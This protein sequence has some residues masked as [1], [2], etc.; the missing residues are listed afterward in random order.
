[1]KGLIVINNSPEKIFSEYR[2]CRSYKSALGS[3]GLYEQTAINE[4]FFAGDQWY[5]AACPSDRPL[6]RHNII[7]RIGDFKMSQLVSSKVSVR[8]SAEGVP[9]TVSDARNIANE[10]KALASRGSAIYTPLDSRNEA[11]L[12]VSALNSYRD[13]V[14]RRVGLSSLL[15]TALRN[16]YISGS[17]FIYTYFDPTVRTGLYA[18]KIGGKAILGDIACEVIRAENVYFG[19]PSVTKLQS[20]PY[21]ILAERKPFSD[22]A[23]EAAV[24]G[25]ADLAEIGES[26]ACEKCTLLTKLYKKRLEDGSIHIFAVKVCE[27]F[28]VREEWDTGVRLY[29]LSMFT[30][31]PRD[32]NIY[33]D[34]EVTYLIPNQIA[35]NRMITASVWSAMSTGMPLMLVNGELV[36]E[37]ITND[38][39]QI[40]RVWGSAEEI[41]SAV[42]YINPPDFST[43]YN[44]SVETLISNTLSQSGATDAALGDTEAHNTSAIIELREA[45]SQPLALLKNRYY[46]FIEDISIIWAEFFVTMYGKRSLKINDENGVWY[47]PFDAAR[48]RDLLL[49]V[50]VVL[51]DSVSKSEADSVALLSSLYEKGA[52]SATQYIKRLPSGLVPDCDTLIEQMEAINNESI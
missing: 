43:G 13:T 25:R 41:N 22:I 36:P 17:G 51:T 19:D 52:I 18:D 42:R 1:M 16:A 6:V 5:G 8:Y 50:S 11:G 27:K 32:N 30:W 23:F 24:H 39:G 2:S 46:R 9:D 15:D 3:R 38:P 10:R 12:M 20:Q 48:Y 7:K 26:E 29:P 49:S 28:T 45:S 44:Q 21:I 34:S 33:G 35:I 31:E 47:F 37:D 4:R 40:I 14:A